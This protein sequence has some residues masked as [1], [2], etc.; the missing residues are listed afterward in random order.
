[1]GNRAK[2]PIEGCFPAR[3]RPVS[4]P[5]RPASPFWKLQRGLGGR[6][7]E[8]TQSEGN[9]APLVLKKFQVNSEPERETTAVHRQATWP[10]YLQKRRGKVGKCLSPEGARFVDGGGSRGLGCYCNFFSAQKWI[11]HGGFRRALT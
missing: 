10:N 1:M 9:L 3:P 6:R 8:K 11:P 5:H 7:P 4:C 2:D